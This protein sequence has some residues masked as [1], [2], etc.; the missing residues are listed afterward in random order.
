MFSKKA[1]KI[2]KIFTVN[3]TL[4]SKCQ[5]DS[6]DFFIFVTFLENT[7]LDGLA[8]VLKKDCEICNNLQMMIKVPF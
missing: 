8:N 6:E 5:I 4:C 7:N 3:L 1:T 2:D